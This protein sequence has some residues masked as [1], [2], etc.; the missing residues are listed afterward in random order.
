MSYRNEVSTIGGQI[1]HKFPSYGPEQYVLK[2]AMN[3]AGRNSLDHLAIY[4]VMRGKSPVLQLFLNF[5]SHAL[6]SMLPLFMGLAA[7]RV[8]GPGELFLSAL[9]LAPAPA[10]SFGAAHAMCCLPAFLY[11]EARWQPSTSACRPRSRLMPPG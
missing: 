6:F 4:P 1:T 3:L 2:K 7:S 9:A 8:L 10:W 11:L 5:F